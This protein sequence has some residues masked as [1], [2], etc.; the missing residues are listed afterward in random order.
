M[1]RSISSEARRDIPIILDVDVV[2][3]GGGSAGLAAALTSARNG[4]RTALVERYGFF[5]GNAV[6]AYV[7]TVCGLYLTEKKDHRILCKGFASA[8]AEALASSGAAFG[9]VPYKNTAVLVY[10]PWAFKRLA[11]RLVR[12]EPMLTPLL[13][14]NVTEV[15]R[16]GRS[17]EA[18]VVGSKR[19]PIALTGSVFIDC[20]GDAD[21]AFHAGL[22]T[23]SAEMKQFPSMQFLMENVDVQAA[24]Q[25]GLDHLASLMSESDLSRSSGA[26][27]PTMRSGEVIGAMTRVGINGRAPDMTDVFEATAAEMMGRDEAERAS[28]FLIEKMPGFASSFI[29]DT[30]AQLGVRE[31][32]RVVGDYVLTGD[33]VLSGKR[34]DDGVAVGAWPQ[35]FHTSG[36]ETRW[37]WLDAGSYYQIPLR[38]LIAKDADNLLVAGRCISATHEALAS[39]RVI[40]P[41]MGQGEACGVAA[42]SC[43]KQGVSVRALDVDEVRATLVSGGAFVG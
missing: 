39:T 17:I 28:Q 11:D 29:A 21:L 35:E 26:V 31:T 2:V 18:V 41:S 38:S 15:L 23:D 30:P 24:Y 20:S 40:A 13:H 16:A 6:S 36:R 3:V 37:N 19:G 25:A 22:S 8:W 34:F 14:C 7:G 33:D 5:G 42:A 4:A 32:R 12:A 10:V 9:P 27:L 43:I 1:Q